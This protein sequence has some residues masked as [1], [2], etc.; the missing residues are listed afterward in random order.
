MDVSNVEA[1][2]QLQSMM[3]SYRGHLKHA[4]HYK[5]M[6]TKL[7]QFLWL[8]FLYQYDDKYSWYS[9][10]KP[11]QPHYFLEQWDFFQ[12]HPANIHIIMQ[13]GRRWV[14]ND[15]TL[16]LIQSQLSCFYRVKQPLNTSLWEVDDPNKQ[17]II[18]GLQQLKSG[19]GVV[20]EQGYVHRNLKQRQLTQ[21][22]LAKPV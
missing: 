18:Q 6:Q 7:K 9:R 14:I 15:A 8:D 20:T 1:V 11:Q 13:K 10:L 2:S 17:R 19:Y 4:K 3:A 16:V 21:L 12:P 5:L 22:W